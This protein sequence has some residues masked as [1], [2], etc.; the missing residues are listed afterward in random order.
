M[1]ISGTSPNSACKRSGKS[2]WLCRC[3]NSDT[4]L[5]LRWVPLPD[6][7]LDVAAKPS[8]MPRLAR[9][10]ATYNKR[11]SSSSL[12]SVMSLSSS[13]SLRPGPVLKLPRNGTNTSGYSKPLLLW[14]VTTCTQ[15]ASVSK[16][17][18][19]SSGLSPAAW[20][21]CAKNCNKACGP[22]KP[23]AA[24]CSNSPRCS[25]L[26]KLR[27]PSGCAIKRCAMPWLCIHW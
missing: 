13:S 7:P 9:V 10:S 21:C 23:A 6:K 11:M 14:K 25:R 4:A 19:C 16:R 27:C 5:R 15:C 26:V 8:H 3:S 12:D 2:S 24:V 20:I 17:I 1:A 18:F 22:C